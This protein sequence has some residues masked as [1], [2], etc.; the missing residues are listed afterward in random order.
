MP[1]YEYQCDCG[2]SFSRFLPIEKRHDVICECGRTPR[3]KISLAFHRMAKLFS[4]LDHDGTILHQ[5]Q[6]IEKT[7]PPDYYPSEHNLL[8]V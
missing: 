5:R 3:I 1:I 7:P 4:V 6:T 8:E 2:K